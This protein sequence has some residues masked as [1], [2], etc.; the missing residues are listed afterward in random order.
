ML[1]YLKQTTMKN[2]IIRNQRKKEINRLVKKFIFF[3][4]MSFVIIGM[5]YK[6]G[7]AGA[8]WKTATYSKSTPNTWQYVYNHLSEIVCLS[9]CGGVIFTLISELIHDD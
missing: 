2:S 6:S 4:M 8:R 9:L 5:E 7:S 1:F 3:L